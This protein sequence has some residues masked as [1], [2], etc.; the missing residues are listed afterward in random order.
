MKK[1]G[2]PLILVT[3]FTLPRSYS[4]DFQLTIPGLELDGKKLMISYDIMAGKNKLIPLVRIGHLNMQ[5]SPL[6]LPFFLQGV[7]IC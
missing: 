3:L 6:H 1:Q 7:Q 5:R 2:T 4:Q